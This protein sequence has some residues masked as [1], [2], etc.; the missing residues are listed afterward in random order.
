[1]YYVMGGYPR[2]ISLQFYIKNRISESDRMFHISVHKNKGEVMKKLK[3]FFMK[4]KVFLGG[5]VLG[6][7]IMVAIYEYFPELLIYNK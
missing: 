1:M 3:E 7:L 2:N 5:F 6:A 4:C